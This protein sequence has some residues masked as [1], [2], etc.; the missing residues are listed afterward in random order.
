[1]SQYLDNTLQDLDFVLKFDG[2]DKQIEIN[3]E[4]H[5]E[6]DLKDSTI[7]DFKFDDEYYS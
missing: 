6:N 1:M 7:V 2:G 4:P 5:D 3:F